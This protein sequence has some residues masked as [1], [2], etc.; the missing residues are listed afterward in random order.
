MRAFCFRANKHPGGSLSS[1]DALTALFFGS[2]ARLGMLPPGERDH[3]VHSKGHAAAPMFFALWAHGFYDDLSIEELAEFGELHHPVPR[4]PR[5]DLA[6]GVE[7]STGSLGQGLSFGCGLALADRSAGRDLTSYVLLGDGECSEGQVWEAAM[8]AHRLELRNIVAL[9]DA[10]GSGSCVKLDRQEWAGRWRGF[11]WEALEVDGH[12]MAALVEALEH[13]HTVERP[14]ALVL[15]TVKGRGLHREVEG[16][17][18]LSSEAASR[19]LPDV[20]LSA[21]ATAALK[22]VRRYHPV[23]ASPEHPLPEAPA[24]RAAFLSGMSGRTAGESVVT[25]QIGGELAEE[26]REASTLF[27]SPDAIRNSGILP[28]MTVVG[29]WS[30]HNPDSNVLELG[31]AEQDAASLL[32]GAAANGM[33]PLLFSMEGF[34]WRMLDQIRQSACF[35]G[36][37]IVFVGTSGGV[38]DLL[39][40][41]VQS[42]TLLLALD[43]MEGLDLLEAADANT[44]KILFAEALS[45]GRPTY[46]RLPHEAVPQRSTLEELARRDLSKGYLVHR[47]AE[48][49][50]VVVLTAGALRETALDVA[51]RLGEA[52]WSCRVAEVIAA[53]RFDRL[54]DGDR[55]ALFPPESIAC[56]IHNA[57]SAFLGRRAPAGAVR[58]GADGPGLCGKSL[59]ELYRASGLDAAT[60]TRELLGKLAGDRDA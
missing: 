20:D 8:T 44:A 10:N 17:N 4:M 16:T 43:A 12:D 37:P 46:L 45:S 40:P 11:G 5:R 57:P 6:R 54:G 22:I 7:M 2:P 58:F 53:R 9:L 23:P 39:G 41:M 27:A 47:D 56:T 38:G 35:M 14:A 1:V 13:A 55:A 3:F 25:K 31:I 60:I 18:T 34:Y 28:W 21:S 42:D 29:S 30:W 24:G 15:H 59:T 32:A 26:L 48:A 49:P 19:H 33:R 36:L 51:D 52:G 50:D